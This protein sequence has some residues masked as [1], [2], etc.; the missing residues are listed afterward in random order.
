MPA[1]GNAEATIRDDVWAVCSKGLVKR[2]TVL[3][4]SYNTRK[5]VI[6]KY[7]LIR[8]RVGWGKEALGQF[9]NRCHNPLS[10]EVIQL[11]LEGLVLN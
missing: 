6:I 10:R 4:T 8:V 5:G 2:G 9:R 3:Q 7:R 11:Y 1:S